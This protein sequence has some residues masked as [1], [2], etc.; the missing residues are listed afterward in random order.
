LLRSRDGGL[1]YD[2]F[3]DLP[4]GAVIGT[5]TT[6]LPP[7][8]PEYWDEASTVTVTLLSQTD[9]LESVSAM[10][11][12]NGANAAVIGEEVLQFRS[13]VLIAPL[14][15]RLE[16]LLRGRKG[17]EDRIAGHVAGERF[18]L[19]TGGGLARPVVEAGELGLTR[20]YR[21]AS[22]GTSVT[23]A[24]PFTF[25]YQGR[26]ARPY[27]PVHLKGARDGAG[28]LALSWIRRTRFEAPWLDD[29]DAPLGEASEAY[30]IDIMDGA[31][32]K[33]TLT[34]TAPAA[35]YSAADQ[36]ADFG[37]LQAAVPVRIY[38]ISARAGRGLP[39]ENV[40]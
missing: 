19:L 33:R 14:T 15:Y 36:I 22:V 18:V 10:Q 35:T 3:A 23:D 21:A 24:V 17:T 38:Q 40:L 30:E 39:A 11:V 16:G 2:P 31:S 6:A 37:S 5:A 32:V 9:Q 26:W 27:A 20:S 13:A 8:A 12:L 29:V 7:A 28:N 4:T 25:T 34:S 1:N